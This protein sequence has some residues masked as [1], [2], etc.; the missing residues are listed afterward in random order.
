MFPD[1]NG[2]AHQTE[3]E[4]KIRWMHCKPVLKGPEGLIGAPEREKCGS[5]AHNSAE[6]VLV[7]GKGEVEVIKALGVLILGVVEHANEG[8]ETEPELGIVLKYSTKTK[9]LLERLER[10]LGIGLLGLLIEHPQKKE[11]NNG[12]GETEPSS[13][14]QLLH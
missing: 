1:V 9:R 12:V 7:K 14:A 6:E 2:G 5:L 13:C 10:Q 4:G 3:V 8:V 11:A